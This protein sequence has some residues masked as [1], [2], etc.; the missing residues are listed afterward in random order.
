MANNWSSNTPSATQYVF[1]EIIIP[2]TNGIAISKSG[3]QTGN[4]QAYYG[5]TL[6]GNG[7][8]VPIYTPNNMTSLP[9]SASVQGIYV[10]TNILM[11]DLP[12][13]EID[14]T[15]GTTYKTA[16]NGI[17]G[18]PRAIIYFK[19][20]P[21]QFAQQNG[22]GTLN[23]PPLIGDTATLYAYI[24]PFT[25]GDGSG[26]ILN[27]Y[28]LPDSGIGTNGVYSNYWFAF[29]FHIPASAITK[30]YKFQITIEYV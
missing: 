13:G 14:V 2:H 27:Q 22:V 30:D 5:A 21:I 23:T 16:P 3:Y 18:G 19:N 9:V 1:P 6:D 17:T 15:L 20:N 29:Q 4:L 25:F 26:F 10:N 12:S 24:D 11:S 7:N 28:N 8:I